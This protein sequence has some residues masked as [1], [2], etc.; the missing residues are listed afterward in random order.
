VALSRSKNAS[1]SN[2]SFAEK[3][4]G[5]EKSPGF[6]EGSF[7]ENRIAL[8]DN[9][10]P[11]EIRDRGLELLRFIEQRWQVLLGDEPTKLKLLRLDWLPAV[12]GS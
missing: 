4:S 10:T 12:N 2:G 6:N 5:T 9:W 11:F 7:S 8:S 3:K 1:L